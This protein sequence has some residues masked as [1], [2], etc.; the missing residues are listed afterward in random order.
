MISCYFLAFSLFFLM[1]SFLRR[2][3][4]PFAT[5]I[6]FLT[7]SFPINLSKSAA[8]PMRP[9]ACSAFMWRSAFSTFLLDIFSQNLPILSAM[10]SFALICFLCLVV[11][12]HT[13]PKPQFYF[14]KTLLNGHTFTNTR[15]HYNI[16]FVFP[17]LLGHFEVFSKSFILW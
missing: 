8:T 5:W 6:N 15:H 9:V 1:S 16:Y 4:G 13:L 7:R 11:F 3:S 14:S 2:S 17:C 10:F 12:S